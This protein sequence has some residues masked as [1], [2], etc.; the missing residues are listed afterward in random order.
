MKYV[1]L[2]RVRRGRRYILVGVFA[3]DISARERAEIDVYPALLCDIE[4]WEFESSL[5]V[6]PAEQA[7]TGP[8]APRADI[9]PGIA[10]DSHRP[11]ILII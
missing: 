11:D 4:C 5:P 1:Y 10:E 9:S 6:S 8:H 2:L 3:D 7:D